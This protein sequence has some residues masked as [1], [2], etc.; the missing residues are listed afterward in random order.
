MSKV[1]FLKKLPIWFKIENYAVLKDLDNWSLLNQFRIR[2]FF[3]KTYNNSDTFLNQITQ[4]T[5]KKI[6]HDIK[7]GK[8]ISEQISMSHGRHYLDDKEEM[9]KIRD[10]AKDNGTVPVVDLLRPFELSKSTD[11]SVAPLELYDLHIID[12][13]RPSLL[14]KIPFES[15]EK[16]RLCRSASFD[17]LIN[18]NYSINLNIDL[19]RNG[20]KYILEQI[21]KLLP[22]W[23]K[24]LRINEPKSSMSL[25]DVHLKKI[26]KFQIIPYYDLLVFQQIENVKIPHRVVVEAIFPDQK[27]PYT[28]IEFRQTILKF[29]NK[30]S[31]DNFNFDHYFS[32]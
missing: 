22:K 18:N 1:K 9:S 10:R 25:T 15:D 3:L 7:S 24:E 14:D 23:R 4:N 20:D 12:L 28:E 11:N 17:K 5:N 31:D 16:E 26:L 32:K 19:K 30:I 21:K 29:V 27:D 6:W 13:Y 8:I 2:E